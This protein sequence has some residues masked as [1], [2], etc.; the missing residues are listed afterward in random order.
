MHP[1]KHRRELTV[2]V[3]VLRRGVDSGVAQTGGDHNPRP[4]SYASFRW[5][6][7]AAGRGEVM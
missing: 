6:L 1:K 2:V 4:L 7:A 3:V 5:F